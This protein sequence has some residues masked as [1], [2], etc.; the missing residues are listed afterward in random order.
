MFV[1][2]SLEVFRDDTR[3]TTMLWERISDMILP[4]SGALF[5]LPSNRPFVARLTGLDKRFGFQREFQRFKLDYSRANSIGSRGVFAVYLID[6][7][8]S[9]VFEIREQT[10]W[11][12]VDRRFCRFVNGDEVRIN[13]EEVIRCLS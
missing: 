11:R 10:S 12:S 4:G 1:H 2:L 7:D 9:D 13:R 6:A 5:R 8:P 3:Q